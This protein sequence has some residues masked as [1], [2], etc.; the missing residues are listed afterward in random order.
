[1]S[2]KI[3]IDDQVLEVEDGITILEAAR[4]NGIHIPTL[5]YMKEL[6]PHASC[7]LCIVQVEGARTFLPSCATKVRDG[8]VVKTNTD[9]IRE[10]RKRTLE[11]IMAH[12]PVDCHH[13]LRIG[14]S[15]EE[16]LDPKFC[17]MCFWCDCVRDGICELQQLNRE[18]HVDKLPFEIEG[19]RYEEDK[20]LG[21]IIRNSNKCVKCRR[22]VDV[23]N[24][25]Q[26]VHNLALYG[27][28]QEYQVTA[29]LN[30]PMNESICVRCGRCVDIC[31]T[32]AIYMKEHIDQMVFYAHN[33][34][35][36]TIGMVS[37]SVL[38]DLE[39]LYKMEPGNLDGH[40]VIA[41]LKKLGVDCIISEEQVID[42]NQA[43]AEE[44]IAN[45]KDSLIISNSPAAKNFIDLYYPELSNKVVYYESL[46][47][48]FAKEAKEF[49][50]RLNYDSDK[51]KTV[52]FTGNN[53]NGAEAVEKGTVDFSMN[54][55][56]IYRMFKRTGIDVNRMKPVDALKTEMDKE[57]AFS[58]VTAPVKFNYEKNPE[59]L[60][61]DG[62]M[63]AVA[64][65]LGQARKLLD[66]VING[67]SKYEIVRICA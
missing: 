36:K 59:V 20:S 60:K 26:S 29:A 65:N 25:V 24:E 12:H 9:E 13:C 58:A 10:N 33:Y 19:S 21:S 17:E 35:S 2:I 42:K 37:A 47:E 27:R 32:G 48:T 44:I 39:K 62:K 51:Y 38:P 64:H 5:C 40:K 63:C 45:A 1:M 11:M 4:Q 23:C 14:S 34:D 61:I 56:E 55:R 7:R 28:G 3:T 66:E 43:A 8:M 57:Y 16:D 18:Y 54:A 53:E 52:V 22:C 6:E 15:K 50:T 41:G 67:V 49:V 31:P 30:K 46:Q